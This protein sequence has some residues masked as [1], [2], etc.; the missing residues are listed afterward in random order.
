VRIGAEAA[1]AFLALACSEVCAPLNPTFKRD[2]F[3][4]ELGDLGARGFPLSAG[5]KLTASG[6]LSGLAHVA[7][8][9]L[10]D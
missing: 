4:F 6:S 3:D 7:G 1:S 5:R 9:R 10:R 2:V 8:V